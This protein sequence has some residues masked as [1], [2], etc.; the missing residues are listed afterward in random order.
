MVATATSGAA[1]STPSPRGVAVAEG[2]DYNWEAAAADG[3]KIK[4]LACGGDS[5]GD[6]GSGCGGAACR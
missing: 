2:E 1:V 6:G 4:I 3:P 5:G